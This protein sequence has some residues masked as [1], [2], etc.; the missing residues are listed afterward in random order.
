MGVDVGS[1]IER[2]QVIGYVGSSGLATGPHLHYA[3]ER[4]GLYVDP[5]TLNPSS[6]Q[7]VPGSARRAFE[8]AEREVLKQLAVLPETSRPQAVS[9]SRVAFPSPA[10]PRE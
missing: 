7:A 1:T 3:L 6:E 2:G 5:L 8:R 4:D 9:L 10:D